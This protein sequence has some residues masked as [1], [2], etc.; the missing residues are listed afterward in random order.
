MPSFRLPQPDLFAADAFIWQAVPGMLEPVTIV[1]RVALNLLKGIDQQRAILL[2]NTYRFAQGF[3]SN[4]VLLWGARGTG[5]SALVKAVHATVAIKFSL[6]LVEIYRGD[7][8]TLS[9]LLGLLTRAHS[10]R[11][12]ILFCDDLSFDAGDQSYKALK[13]I[14]EGGIRG[15]PDT[16]LFYAT[17]NRRHLIPRETIENE[18][19][20]ALIPGEVVDEKISLS[21]R[22]GLWL[23]FYAIDQT[24]YLEIVH[25]Y[26]QAFDLPITPNQLV[27][28]ANN[29]ATTRGTRSGRIAW[30]FIQDLTGRLG[31][32]L[33]SF[34]QPAT[35]K[36]RRQHP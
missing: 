16:V 23:G 8:Q 28:E 15:Q 35:H 12:C 10:P 30:Q 24:T 11:R 6:A 19:A 29:W 27:I 36:C 9:N 20:D 14:L 13:S 3:P 18:Q 21:D 5:K 33:P 26:A 7:I 1:N 34:P 25:T 22:F 31:C 2:D 32:Q 17:S 4:N